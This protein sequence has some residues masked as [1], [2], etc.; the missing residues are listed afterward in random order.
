MPT[1]TQTAMDGEGVVGNAIR[2][3]LFNRDNGHNEE[4]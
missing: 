2:D 4:G 1:P 3:K